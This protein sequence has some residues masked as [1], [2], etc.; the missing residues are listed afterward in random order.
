M[1]EK[2]LYE[3]AQAMPAPERQF[4]EA[5]LRSHETAAKPRS[6]RLRPALIAL[7][8]ILIF[9]MTAGAYRYSQVQRSMRVIRS[10]SNLVMPDENAWEKTQKL[11]DDLDVSLPETLMDT[12]FEHGRKFSVVPSGTPLLEA[13][14]TDFYNPVTVHYSNVVFTDEYGNFDRLRYLDVTIGS[15]QQSYWKHY[16]GVAEDGTFYPEATHV[17]NYRGMELRGYSRTVTDDWNEETFV[18]HS[19][20]WIDDE[21]D[22]CFSLSVARTDS[23][24]FLMDCAKQII[25]LNR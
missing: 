11:L 3:A 21:K 1:M 14:F 24:E 19:V 23:V 4:E 20:Q 15:T 13:M 5:V 25:D 18:I 12:P 16:F 2:K 7:T 17:E 22:L 8:I 10:Y 9:T 6:R